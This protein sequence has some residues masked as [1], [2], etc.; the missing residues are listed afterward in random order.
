M[1][2]QI[3]S[4]WR[5]RRLRSAPSELSESG[6]AGCRVHLRRVRLPNDE[7]K[8]M[9]GLDSVCLGEV[10]SLELQILRHQFADH[11][12]AAVEPRRKPSIAAFSS[13]DRGQKRLPS[14]M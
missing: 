8:E 3:V 9:G 14:G 6:L 4:R 7:R 11:D 1:E 10:F 2:C 12:R 13:S 5:V